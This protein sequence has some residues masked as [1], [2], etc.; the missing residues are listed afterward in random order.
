[1]QIFVLQ[2]DSQSLLGN[3]VKDAVKPV[4]SV[5]AIHA[6]AGRGKK[7]SETTCHYVFTSRTFRFPCPFGPFYAHAHRRHPYVSAFPPAPFPLNLPTPPTRPPLPDPLILHKLGTHAFTD[8]NTQRRR[9]SQTDRHT[10]TDTLTHTHTDTDTDT[11]RHTH[12]HTHTHTSAHAH[13]H[14]HARTLTLKHTL[15]VLPTHAYA[16][17][18][19]STS[20]RLHTHIHTHTPPPPH[21]H[22]YTPLF[23]CLSVCLS[24]CLPVCL[25]V[26]QSLFHSLSVFDFQDGNSSAVCDIAGLCPRTLLQYLRQTYL[27]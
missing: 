5:V 25:S 21:T 19:L 16:H 7:V 26:C 10:D 12:T 17:A 8:R 14:T 6:R 27:P 2:L 20:A 24:V 9:H 3:A 13:T 23:A 15:P 18:Y 11:H 1:M 22:T 4:L